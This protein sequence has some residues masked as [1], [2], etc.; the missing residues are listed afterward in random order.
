M[1]VVEIK[2]KI[3]DPSRSLLGHGVILGHGVASVPP[4]TA[5]D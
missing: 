1:K 5:L 2:D 4:A 3:S